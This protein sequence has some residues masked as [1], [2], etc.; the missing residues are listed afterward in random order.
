MKHK[1]FKYTKSAEV[2]PI[3]VNIFLTRKFFL[4]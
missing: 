2:S 4:L 3:D 1:Y